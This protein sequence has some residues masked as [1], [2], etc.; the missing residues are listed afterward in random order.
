MTVLGIHHATLL[1]DDEQRASW[2]YGEV[3]GLEAKP[4][5]Q[6]NFPGLF[7]FCGKGQ[8]LHII[9]SAKPLTRAKDLVIRINGASEITRSFI[10]RHVA[11]VVS[12]FAG[13]K[14]RI[15]ENQVEIVFDADRASKSDPFITTLIAGWSKMYGAPPFFCLDPFGNLLEIIPASPKEG[16]SSQIDKTGR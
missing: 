4:R 7:Y 10:H 15:S 12:D 6:F 1:V 9:V 8:E 5:P 11:L 2:F 13:T 16:H 14:R 3:L